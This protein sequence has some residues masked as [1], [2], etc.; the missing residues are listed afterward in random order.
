MVSGKIDY[1]NAQV[2]LSRWSELDSATASFSSE[3]SILLKLEHG[4]TLALAVL[5]RWLT[6]NAPSARTTV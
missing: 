6:P 4:H 3:W 2:V 5:V 1:D